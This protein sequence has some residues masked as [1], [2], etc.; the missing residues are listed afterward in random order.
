MS[1]TLIVTVDLPTGRIEPDG[2]LDVTVT[3][4]IG[5]LP[6]GS[7]KSTAMPF[8]S[9]ASTVMLF[10]QEPR[11]GSMQSGTPFPLASVSAL[12]H[13]Q[14]PGA[15]LCGSFGQPSLAS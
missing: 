12:P 10:G 1:F 4:P 6:A 11:V 13:P 9:V 14:M 7:M 5:L 8:A 15:V 3:P 2:G